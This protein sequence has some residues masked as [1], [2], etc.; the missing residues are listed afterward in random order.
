MTNGTFVAETRALPGV[1]AAIGRP[2][3][4]L[5]L[6][7]G[8][9]NRSPVAQLQTIDGNGSLPI[10]D[11]A[12]PPSAA[13]VV[14]GSDDA[15]I[16]AEA[17]ALKSFGRPVFLRWC[18]EMNLVASHPG[19]ESPATFVAAWQHIWTVFHNVGATNVAFVWCPALSG[20]DPAPYYPGD[21]FVDWIGVDG[22]DRTG[23]GTF[24]SIFGAFY[25]NW[26]VH[27]KPMMVTETGAPASNQV[28]YLGSVATQMPTMPLFKGFVYF[29][30]LGPLNDWRLGPAGLAA[31]GQ[32]AR[33]SYFVP[34]T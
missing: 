30:A 17:Q 15:Q 22:Y 21:G 10:L 26:S 23:T 32:L 3:T 24:D 9:N 4:L 18:W 14:D 33:T 27:A 31:F 8:W 2:L 29:D 6:Y 13:A 11:W 16:A 20:R 5:H 28:A 34:P 19:V 1:Q 25:A 7:V 12:C